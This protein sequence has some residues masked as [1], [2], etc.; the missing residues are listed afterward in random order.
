WLRLRGIR[1]RGGEEQ[2]GS[3]VVVE[4]KEMRGAAAS[5]IHPGS[6]RDIFKAPSVP[7]RGGFGQIEPIRPPLD[8]E[9]KVGMSVAGKIAH[10]DGLHAA[11]HPESEIPG[12]RL[13]DAR[14]G[15]VIE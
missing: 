9:E 1:R 3:P 12:D 8:P 15:L 5:A 7:E 10:G 14:A 6:R 13:E 4:V 2:I 11:R